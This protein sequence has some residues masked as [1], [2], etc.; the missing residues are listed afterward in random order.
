MNT[1][2]SIIRTSV[3]W[4]TVIRNLGKFGA[5]YEIWD[6]GTPLQVYTYYKIRNELNE[7]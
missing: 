6:H 1:I 4:R 3:Q 5:S 2:E 7:I